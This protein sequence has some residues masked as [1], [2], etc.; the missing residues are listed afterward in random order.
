MDNS[1]KGYSFSNFFYIDKLDW[2]TINARTYN[3]PFTEGDIPDGTKYVKIFIGLKGI[4][5]MWVDDVSFSYSKW[6][7]T[8]KER[9]AWY[10]DEAFSPIEM[11]VPTPKYAQEGNEIKLKA[12]EGVPV[13]VNNFKVSELSKHTEKYLKRKLKIY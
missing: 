10:K 1:F 8:S 4:G 5:T 11:L 6:N 12:N 9:M 7:F 13:I 2:S 3:Y